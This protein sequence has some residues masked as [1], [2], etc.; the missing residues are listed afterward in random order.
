MHQAMGLPQMAGNYRACQYVT[1][2]NDKSNKG[3]ITHDVTTG[4]S[5][6]LYEGET[7]AEFQAADVAASS[8]VPVLYNS[9]GG[10]SV[11]LREPLRGAGQVPCRHDGGSWSLGP[12]AP[13]KGYAPCIPPSPKPYL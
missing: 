13:C 1:P 2:F 6:K 12:L 4:I 8:C 10:I 11:I 3:Y 9:R 7:I 5:G